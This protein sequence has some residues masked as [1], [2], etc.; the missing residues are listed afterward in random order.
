MA[1]NNIIWL[2]LQLFA[3]EGGTG[4]ASASGEGAGNGASTVGNTGDDGQARLLELG[5]PQAVLDKRAK[6]KGNRASVPTMTVETNTASAEAKR[7]VAPDTKDNTENTEVNKTNTEAAP[8]KMSWDE[9]MKD[10]D[11]NKE[12]QKTI[13]ARLKSAKSAEDALNKLTPAIELLARQHNLDINN[14]DYDAL[15][16]AIS[17]DS[18]YYEDKALEMGVSIE[19]A[20]KLDQ[21]NRA[22]ER[23]QREAAQTLERQK[24]EQHLNS[25]RQQG[26]IL[27]QTFPQFDLMTELKNPTF[28]RMTSPSGGVSVEDAYYA[29]H[30]KE[31][32]QASMQVAAQKTAEKISNAIQAGSRRPDENGI[33]SQASSV[34]TFDYR[35]ASTAQRNALK[36]RIRDA[37]ARGEKIYPGS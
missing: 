34:T 15:S 9:I 18:S 5:V 4:G 16:K 36:Q 12:M 13:Q 27:K 28:A 30:R 11:Y 7:Q 22:T 2:D 25:L 14:L 21:E 35:R 32:Q 33:N 24:I 20:K 26:D 1:N 10:P 17:D 37:A 29:V 8:N 23:Q 31:I 19:T 3:G 6:R